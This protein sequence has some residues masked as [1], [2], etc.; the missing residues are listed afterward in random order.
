MNALHMH[1]IKNIKVRQ[2]SSFDTF[3][4]VTVTVTDRDNKSFELQ[5]FTDKDFVPNMEVEHVID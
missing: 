2:D 4:T 1:G 5:L 3:T